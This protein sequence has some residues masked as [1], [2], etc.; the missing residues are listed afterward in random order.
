MLF[1]SIPIEE[2]VWRMGSRA[3]EDHR[4]T[5]TCASPTGPTDAA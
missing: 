3:A 5:S 2:L 4:R 1:K